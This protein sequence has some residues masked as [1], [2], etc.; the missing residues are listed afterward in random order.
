MAMRRLLTLI[1]S[2]IL[3][4]TFV[5]CCKSYKTGISP[6]VRIVINKGINEY[7]YSEGLKQLPKYYDLII[8]HTSFLIDKDKIEDDRLCAINVKN[9]KV[10]WYFPK[11]T[12]IHCGYSFGGTSYQY[13]N[14]II[15]K[16]IKDDSD[17]K[18]HNLACINIDTGEILWERSEI[19]NNYHSYA[20]VHGWNNFVYFTENSNK[21]YL[22]NIETKDV[23]LVYTANDAE[24]CHFKI[25]NNYLLFFED[26]RIILSD[27]YMDYYYQNEAIIL[28]IETGEE[29]FRY[30][31]EPNMGRYIG[32]GIIQDGILYANVDTY[33]TAVDI[34]TGQQLW[35]R[36]DPEAYILEDL[37]V[38][39]GV[40]LKCGG[41]ST[42]GY[43]AQTGELLYKYD[44]FGSHYTTRNGKYAYM[45]TNAGWLAVIDITT[46]NIHKRIDCPDEMFFGSYP[47]FYDDNMYIMGL[48]NYLYCYSADKMER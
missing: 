42:Y 12:D 8:A 2:I 21:I 24:I 41:N 5:S 28:D 23:S 37:I 15:F 10:E 27:D 36:D 31:I 26:R 4:L 1:Y 25:D 45:V 40:V 16:Y 13:R 6:D 14:N 35:E 29:V 18:S 19:I 17:K 32:N 48:P 39:N 9:G 11:N 38:Y 43:N 3:L 7:I 33:I 22:F 30:R 46:G 20:D 44:C 47:T 34:K